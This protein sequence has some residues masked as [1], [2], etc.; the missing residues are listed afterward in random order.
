MSTILC[1]VST[2]FHRPFVPALMHRAV[3]HTLHGLSHPG[4]RASQ[5][6][7]AEMFVWPG[8]NKDV[9]AWARSCLICQWNKL[10][11]H[12]S[13]PG[14][15]P[16]PDARFRYVHL[17]VVGPLPSFNGFT[18]L[19]TCVDRYTR[20]AETIPLPNVEADTIVKAFVSLW[21]AVFG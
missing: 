4:I 2:P 8:M 7:L 10:Q 3:C 17:D 18:H 21:I 13:P 14:T 15:F 5:K 6:L 12:K 9:K 16:S 19:I 11:R 20:W 1:A